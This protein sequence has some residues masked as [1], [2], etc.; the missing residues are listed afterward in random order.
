MLFNQRRLIGLAAFAGA[1][2]C[3]FSFCTRRMKL[4][5][6]RTCRPG[7][8]GRPAIH[9]S[10]FDGIVKLTIRFGIPCANRCP[11]RVILCFFCEFQGSGRHSQISGSIDDGCTLA[12]TIEP[13]TP[14]LA[15]EFGIQDQR[16]ARQVRAQFQAGWPSGGTAPTYGGNAESSS[17]FPRPPVASG[18]S[19]AGRR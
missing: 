8:T 14:G 18:E 10:G 5:I 9:T 17:P 4:H 1:E 19:F 16:V 15:L 12:T 13:G 11:A 6:F 7:C 2:T 3:F